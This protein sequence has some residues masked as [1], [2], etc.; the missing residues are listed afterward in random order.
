MAAVTVSML[1]FVSA[2]MGDSPGELKAVAYRDGR[3]WAEDSVKTAG[4]PAALVLSAER[5][6]FLA[7]DNGDPTDMVPFTSHE[8]AA[9]NGLCLAIVK[10]VPGKAGTLRLT[11]AGGGVGEASLNIRTDVGVSQ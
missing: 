7:T 8:R 10:G 2:A 9:F 3:N 4:D 5:S 1:L 6:G 11:A